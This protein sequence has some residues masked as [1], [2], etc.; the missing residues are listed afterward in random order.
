MAESMSQP[1]RFSDDEHQAVVGG[2][3]ATGVLCPRVTVDTIGFG[4][5]LALVLRSSCCP[6]LSELAR[7]P[8]KGRYLSCDCIVVE[9]ASK[10]CRR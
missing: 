7:E 2:V 6:K 3:M 8:I 1:L 9:S 4:F 10:I 5:P